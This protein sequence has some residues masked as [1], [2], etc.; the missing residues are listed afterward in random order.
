[1]TA[2]V[3]DG[4]AAADD[5]G[6]AQIANFIYFE[7]A[8]AR[9]DSVFVHLSLKTVDIYTPGLACTQKLKAYLVLYRTY[10]VQ[11]GVAR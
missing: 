11:N 5:G 4:A 6:D 2:S 7:D 8:A 1:M 3:A 10:Y 9:V